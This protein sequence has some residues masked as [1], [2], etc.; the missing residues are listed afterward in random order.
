[1]AMSINVNTILKEPEVLPGFI[2]DRHNLNNL[3]NANDIM[4]KETVCNLPNKFE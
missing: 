3:R 1:M 4:L 2:I